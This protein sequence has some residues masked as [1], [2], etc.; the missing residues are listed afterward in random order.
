MY[1][2]MYERNSILQVELK[3]MAHSAPVLILVG[4]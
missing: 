1:S 2:S 3:F 4:H